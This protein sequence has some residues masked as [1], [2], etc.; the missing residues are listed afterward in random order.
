MFTICAGGVTAVGS[1]FGFL[2]RLW[3]R[4]RLLAPPTASVESHRDINTTTANMQRHNPA[5][6]ALTVKI[7]LNGIA[8]LFALFNES[9]PLYLYCFFFFSCLG[10]HS[11]ILN[12]LYSG[13]STDTEVQQAEDKHCIAED[14]LSS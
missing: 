7:F 12:L 4:G 3:G 8:G 2:G 9:L 10:L 13:S 6:L 14:G 5:I 1:T 11:T